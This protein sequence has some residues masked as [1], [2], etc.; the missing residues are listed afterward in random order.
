MSWPWSRSL[1]VG[2]LMIDGGMMEVVDKMC[3]V[4]DLAG[5]K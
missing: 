4:A 2:G 3:D 1:M 5:P